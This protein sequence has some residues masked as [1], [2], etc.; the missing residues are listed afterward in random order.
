MATFSE[1]V[2]FMLPFRGF[3]LWP[4]SLKP[5]PS[6]FHLEDSKLSSK[7]LLFPQQAFDAT[8]V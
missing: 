3:I 2:S 5:F 4:L 8:A 7:P 1:T 6:C